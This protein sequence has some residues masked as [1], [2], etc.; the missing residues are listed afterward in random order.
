MGEIA[1]LL[2]EIPELNYKEQEKLLR[3]LEEINFLRYA[4]CPERED[5][6]HW[7]KLFKGLDEMIAF[8]V[9]DKVKGER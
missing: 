8:K 7:E 3:V 2:H 4:P 1:K 6:S 5:P 9:F